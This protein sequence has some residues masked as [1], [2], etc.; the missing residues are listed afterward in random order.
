M[1][2]QS[3]FFNSSGGDR[4]YSAED[5]AGYFASFIGNGVFPKPSDGLQVMELG[6]MQVQVMPG[7]AWINGYFLNNQSP[8]IFTLDNADGVFGR[9]DRIVARWSL[10]DRTIELVVK[11]GTFTVMPAPPALERGDAVF[12]L[13]LADV[14][15]AAGTTAITQAAITDRRLDTGLCGIVHG[16]VDQVDTVTIFNQYLSWFQNFS[17]QQAMAFAAW[18]STIQDVLD[19]DVAG[20]LLN[21]IH[22]HEQQDIVSESGVHRLRYY[23]GELGFFNGNDW[24][25]IET[26]GSGGVV[27]QENAP[28]D[29]GLLWIKP[30]DGLGRYFDGTWKVM[31]TGYAP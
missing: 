5:W 22:T 13:A 3:G 11:K 7:R 4:R 19:G 30:S 24:E 31:R 25:K 1:Q 20:N 14:F 21:L 26:G 6:A 28:E 2:Q 8:Q 23:D 29:T 9:F 12:E 15:V 17:A 16:V 18:F 10:T 27:V